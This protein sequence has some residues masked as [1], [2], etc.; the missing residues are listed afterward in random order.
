MNMISERR[1]F[2]SHFRV[3]HASCHACSTLSDMLSRQCGAVNKLHI[4]ILNAHMRRPDVI[5]QERRNKEIRN[6]GI[7]IV[8]NSTT[9]RLFMNENYLLLWIFTLI[10]F[11]RWTH[12]YRTILDSA[13]TT[14]MPFSVGKLKKVNQEMNGVRLIFHNPHTNAHSH[15]NFHRNDIDS[16]HVQC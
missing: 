8:T 16:G 7:S 9:C 15:S 11:S 13:A 2:A 1:A 6:N 10:Q 5:K 3:V 4:K 12:A 14:K